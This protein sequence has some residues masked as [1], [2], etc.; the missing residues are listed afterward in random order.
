MKKA[1]FN[2]EAS[3]TA[4]IVRREP[5][6]GG[7]HSIPK[8]RAIRYSPMT[9]SGLSR[10]FTQDSQAQGGIIVESPNQSYLSTYRR[11]RA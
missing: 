10:N 9:P 1:P 5:L 4:L 11:N 2:V 3:R 7:V 6:I 8:G